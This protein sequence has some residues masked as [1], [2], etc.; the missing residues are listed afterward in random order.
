MPPN[1]LSAP[2]SDRPENAECNAPPRRVIVA[3]H[4]LQ[5][6]FRLTRMG[7]YSS[8]Y[9]NFVAKDDSATKIRYSKICWAAP[10]KALAPCD[11]GAGA[12]RLRRSPCNQPDNQDN[13]GDNQ[14]DVNKTSGHVTDKSKEPEHY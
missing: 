3:R 12:L 1:G 4:L 13:D 14:Q 2:K 7:A 8:F 9:R 10:T 5:C 11:Q 6:S